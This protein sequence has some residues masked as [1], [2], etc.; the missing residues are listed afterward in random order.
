MM[1]PFPVEEIESATDEAIAIEP[2]D[3]TSHAALARD[4]AIG[5]TQ[6]TPLRGE[7]EARAPGSPRRNHG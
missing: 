4:A 7:L 6:G 1:T 3:K 2:V 5:L